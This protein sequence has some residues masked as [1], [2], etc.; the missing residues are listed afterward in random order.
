MV[1]LFLSW[2]VWFGPPK[3]NEQ[4]LLFFF[5]W[6]NPR[7]S[8]MKR[9]LRSDWLPE[10]ARW[11]LL[12]RSLDISDFGPARIS[13]LFGYK[14]NP[15]LT[16]LVRS[17]WLYIGLI[18]F[19]I[20]IDLIVVSVKKKKKKKNSEKTNLANIQPSSAFRSVA[21]EFQRLTLA[22]FSTACHFLMR[23][24]VHV[25]TGFGQSNGCSV[26]GV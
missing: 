3:A 12:A 25:F 18:L 5:I 13:S 14:I 4:I 8:K 15:S 9:I 11:A 21:C 23:F 16:K 19:C 2:F 22:L 10:R 24:Y 20:F 6:L 17:K 7:A 26:C 1:C